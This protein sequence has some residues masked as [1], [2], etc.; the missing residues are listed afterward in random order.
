MKIT[1]LFFSAV[2]LVSIAYTTQSCQETTTEL[3][4]FVA[5]NTTFSGYTSWELA[6]TKQGPD[7]ILGAAHE[8]NDS[9]VVRKIY[10]KD[11]QSPVNGAYPV[12]TAIIK[13]M[14]NASGTVDAYMGMVKRG[15]GFNASHNDWEWF[16]LN[17]NG[18]IA[19]DAAGAEQRGANLMNG[20][21]NNCHAAATNDYSFIK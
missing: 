3:T 14:K 13:E 20:A 10:Y 2:A 7:P 1:K 9:T 6:A 16:V 19:T 11:A 21:C 5:D 4:E 17:S 8:G 12:G 15:N 18:T